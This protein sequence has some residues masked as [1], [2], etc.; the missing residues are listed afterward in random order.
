[1]PHKADI[2]A[3]LSI[4]FLIGNTVALVLVWLAGS[5][6]FLT[7]DGYNMAIAWGR[8]AGLLLGY[9]IMLELVLVS[10]VPL[11]EEAFGFDVLNRFHR[12][13]GFVLA[14]LLLAHPLLLAFGYGGGDVWGQLVGFTAWKWVAFAML[15][16][17]FMLGAVKVSVR[18]IRVRMSH[19]AWFS[20]HLFMYAGALLAFFHTISTGDVSSGGPMMYWLLLSAIALLAIVGVRMVR[21]IVRFFWHDFRIERV[22]QEAEDTYSLII[23]GKHIEDFHFCA[24][25]WAQFHILVPG[26]WHHHPFSFSAPYDGK[27]L[28]VTIK[29]LGD[30]SERVHAIPLGT[31]VVVDGPLGRFTRKSAYAGKYCLIGGGV[32]IAPTVALARECAQAGD[33]ATFFAGYRTPD[34]APL[35]SELEATGLPLHVLFSEGEGGRRIDA[36]YIASVCPDIR[37]RDVYICGPGPMMDAIEKGLR[38]IGVP[39]EHIHSER[40]SF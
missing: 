5:A 18:V 28:R 12:G 27:E 29:N 13:L 6:T 35:L 14:Y 15:G 36:T 2:I 16:T 17:I 39:H 21:P 4:V 37:E 33:D 10:R 23:S 32:G 30:Y 25:Q 1:M 3:S 24:G 22:V 31:R 8:L 20:I 38:E 11:L 34:D 9:G 19:D 7:G 26:L 40:F